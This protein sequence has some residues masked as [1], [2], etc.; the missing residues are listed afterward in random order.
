LGG[1]YPKDKLKQNMTSIGCSE[2]IE[3]HEFLF[4]RKGKRK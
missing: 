3:D 2:D 4:L 1:G